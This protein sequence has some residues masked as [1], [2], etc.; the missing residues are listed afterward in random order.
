MYILTRL[1][2]INLNNKLEYNRSKI[3]FPDDKPPS[4]DVK[5]SES[6]IRS[7]IE[8]LRIN[9]LREKAEAKAKAEAELGQKP[10]T[11]T[12]TKPKSKQVPTEGP[13]PLIMVMN[14]DIDFDRTMKMRDCKITE[15]FAR[16]DLEF[17]IKW[18]C[19]NMINNIND[20]IRNDLSTELEQVSETNMD[21]LNMNID[22]DIEDGHELDTEW[23]A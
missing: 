7:Q 14:E 22:I 2:H 10:K 4:E 12:K 20:T 8:Q 19:L 5:K 16:Q 23:N 6:K 3:P 13:N 18:R 11:R 15:L 1:T 9:Y 21:T 17:D